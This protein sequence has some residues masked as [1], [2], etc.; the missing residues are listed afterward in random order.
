[1]RFS[2]IISRSLISICLSA[3]CVHGS[4]I[5]VNQNCF[6]IGQSI[7]ITFENENPLPGDFIG[8]YRPDASLSALNDPSGVQWLWTC[9]SRSCTDSTGISSAT[10]TY[11]DPLTVGTWKVVLARNNPN[12]PPHTGL[13]Q[14]ESF[15]VQSQC[16]TQTEPS[17]AGTNKRTYNVDETITVQYTNANP[18][19]GD[20]IGVYPASV[21]LNNLRQATLWSWTCGFDC[22]TSV[23]TTIFIIVLHITIFHITIFHITIIFHTFH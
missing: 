1:M 14:S 19:E 22:T 9:G 5:Q 10:L 7:Q 21:D 8:I 12:G 23:S 20:W 4:S 16:N 11:S 2:S 18:K 15:Q 6:S 3:L 17:S 13:L